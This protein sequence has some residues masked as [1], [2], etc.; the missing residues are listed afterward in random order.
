[1]GSDL[2]NACLWAMRDVAMVVRGIGYLI[3]AFAVVGI[4][5]L[6]LICADWFGLGKVCS[7]GC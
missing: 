2:L 1:M 6:T 3:V 5:N 4:Q 7:L